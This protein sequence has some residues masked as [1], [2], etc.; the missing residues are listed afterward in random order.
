MKGTQN[1]LLE[2]VRDVEARPDT[3]WEILTT[4][5]LFGAWMEGQAAFEPRV[6]SPF[7]IQFPQYEMVISGEVVECDPDSYRLGLTWGHESGHNSDLLPP[8]TTLLEFNLQETEEGTRVELRHSR[9][10]SEGIEQELHGGWRFHLSRLALRA[11]RRDLEPALGRALEHWFSAWNDKDDESRMEALRSCCA[12]DVV[13]RDDWT[14][15]QGV[16]LLSLHISNCFRFMPGWE[17]SATGDVRI[18]RGEALVGW[19]SLGLGGAA[20]QGHNHLKMD[21]DGTIR[22]VVGF[23]IPTD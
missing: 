16:E 5:E 15:M 22:R 11:N 17:L 12:D 10:P 9:I 8:G 6:G 23:Q 14:A 20:I 19:T 7:R 18:C 3:V 4:A 1:R 21:L 2:L 13:F